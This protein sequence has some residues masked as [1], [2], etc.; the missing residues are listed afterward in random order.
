MRVATLN[1]PLGGDTL[2]RELPKAL[3]DSAVI[4]QAHPLGCRV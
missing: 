3:R 1:A 4:F 2:K